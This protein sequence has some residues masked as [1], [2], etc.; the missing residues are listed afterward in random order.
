[1]FI[2]KAVA[3]WLRDLSKRDPERVVEFLDHHGEQ[4]KPF[5]RKEASKYLTIPET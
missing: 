3:W 4:M 5:A 1:W 2:Q